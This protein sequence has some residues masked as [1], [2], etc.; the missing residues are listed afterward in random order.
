M[1]GELLVLPLGMP[2]PYF[3]LEV[4]RTIVECNALKAREL[5]LYDKGNNQDRYCLFKDGSLISRY[6]LQKNLKKLLRNEYKKTKCIR[7]KKSIKIAESPPQFDGSG[8]FGK[9]HNT[10]SLGC[11]KYVGSIHTENKEK[12]L[13]KDERGQVYTLG[14]GD[15]MGESDGVIVKIDDN[16]IYLEQNIYSN[17]VSWSTVTTKFLK[18]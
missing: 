16:A 5:L 14:I 13:I 11:L 4:R 18:N 17:G 2:H 1:P 8:A 3:G 7:W 12:V 15:Y 10:V 6:F 9:L